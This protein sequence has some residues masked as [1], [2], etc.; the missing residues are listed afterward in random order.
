MDRPKLPLYCLFPLSDDGGVTEFCYADAEDAA[1]II[2]RFPEKD[3]AESTE[4][5]TRML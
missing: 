4:V 2:L 3:E 5:Q 1:G